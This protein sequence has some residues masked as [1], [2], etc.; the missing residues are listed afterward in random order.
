ME[1]DVIT[2]QDLFEFKIE[3]FNPDRTI[4]GDL[5]PTGLRPVFISKFEK[6]GIDLPLSIFGERTPTST[7]HAA[8]G[9]TTR[10]SPDGRRGRRSSS[11]RRRSRRRV[12]EL[13]AGQERGVPEPGVP[14]H[15]P[16][17]PG[18]H[19]GQGRVSENGGPVDSLCVTTPDR[20]HRR[21]AVLLIDTSKSDGRASRSR[22][23]MEA[24]RAFSER[25]N[26]NQQLAIVGFDGEQS[27]CSPVHH[28]AAEIDAALAKPIV[29]EQGTASTTVSRNRSPEIGQ[30]PRERVDRPALRRRGRRQRAASR[31]RR[32]RRSEGGATRVFSVGLRSG[33]TTRPALERARRRRRAA[34][35]RRPRPPTELDT[36][37]R[38]I[39]FKLANEYEV[40]WRSLQG[41]GRRCNV[42]IAVNGS[43]PYTSSYTTP[44]LPAPPPVTYEQ[45][46]IDK[47][48]QSWVFMLLVI[49][50][51]RAADRLRD[52]HHRPQAR[53]H[54]RIGALGAVRHDP[55]R[56]GVR[57]EAPQE[58]AMLTATKT[59]PETRSEV[60]TSLEHDLE[61]ADIRISPV[62]IALC[63]TAAV[64]ADRHDRPRADLPVASGE[65]WSR[66][67][68]APLIARAIL[69]NKCPPPASRSASSCP[70]TS[71]CSP[72]RCAR[73]TASS[74]V[75]P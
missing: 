59:E 51:G 2:L 32:R 67:S 62:A 4:V 75:S 57:A 35:T 38:G 60:V 17:E 68:P 58:V 22:T 8:A 16:E 70:T 26:P 47:I 30:R 46:F 9:E 53:R 56:G 19:R 11:R 20:R 39:G 73:V 72:A 41:P 52:L 27:T 6:R 34:P 14:R 12:A 40:S 10:D 45:G 63:R 5:R 36:D 1:S 61:I 13:P 50:A 64:H 48:V 74:A 28:D 42:V 71:T 15:A 55:V 7:S 44:D 49:G 54:A 24:A 69:K 37:L 33:V 43:L 66:R 21:G 65:C 25:R 31:G 23:P 3:S 18:A 29:L